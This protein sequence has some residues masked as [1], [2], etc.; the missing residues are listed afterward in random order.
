MSG[1]RLGRQLT[2]REEIKMKDQFLKMSAKLQALMMQEEGQDLIEYALIV[3]LVAFAATAG[4]K[5]LATGINTAFT[6]IAGTLGTYI[7]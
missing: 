6:N 3:A 4:M 2:T 7:T 1:L 5:A